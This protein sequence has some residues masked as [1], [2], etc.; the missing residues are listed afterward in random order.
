MRI[1]VFPLCLISSVG[2]NDPQPTDSW[3]MVYY[4]HKMLYFKLVVLL[5]MHIY[6]TYHILRSVFLSLKKKNYGN[7]H[8]TG[9]AKQST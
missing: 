5:C 2:N 7:H 4:P 1:I 6:W 3:N 9:K 8:E